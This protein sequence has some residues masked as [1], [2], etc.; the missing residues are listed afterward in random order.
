MTRYESRVTR[1]RPLKWEWAVDSIEDGK[2]ISTMYGTTPFPSIA[3][4]RAAVIRDH[5]ALEA[6]LKATT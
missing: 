6:L 5:L 3:Y 2:V 1:L 4:Q